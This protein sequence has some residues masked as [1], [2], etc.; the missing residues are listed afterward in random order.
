MQFTLQAE[1][2]KKKNSLLFFF[3]LKKEKVLCSCYK[4]LFKI[5]RYACYISY[6]NTFKNWGGKKKSEGGTTTRKD[7][8]LDMYAYEYVK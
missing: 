1:F 3:S 8:H 5:F 6:Y 7:K 2:C 4:L